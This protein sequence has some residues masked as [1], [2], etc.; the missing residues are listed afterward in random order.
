[1]S[2]RPRIL[3][4][5]G[6]G[7]VSTSLLQ[8][9]SASSADVMQARRPAV[10]LLEPQTLI[11]VV[12]RFRPTVV[13]NAAAYTAVDK[14]EDEPELAQA[15]N[16]TGA[17]TVAKAAA[18]VGAAVVHFSTDYVF[19]GG[20]ETPCLETDPVEPIGVYGRT[21][22]LGEQLVAAANPRHVILRTAWVFSPVG[23][24]FVRTILRLLSE[25]DELRIV[26]DQYGNPTYAPDLAAAVEAITQKL[27]DAPEP[28][29]FGVFHAVNAGST[30]WFDFARAINEA[31]A[32]RGALAKIVRPITTA[33]YPT[34][35][36][37]P[38]Y[39]VLSTDK[40]QRVYGITFRPWQQ[41]LDDCLDRLLPAAS[42]S[43]EHQHSHQH[44]PRP[45]LGQ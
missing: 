40:L 25:R 17:E 36:R 11:D 27:A 15:V 35:A 3:I 2:S 28:K 43:P 16:A 33:D 1:L 37:R 23:S 31:A 38:A 42:A 39:S 24:N 30:T 26:S 45:E 10:D 22:L 9:L 8:R 7:Q 44:S 14:A 41:A 19:A 29:G 21:K 20:N 5:G 6:D 18:L 12:S 4:I 34:K 13:V 32:R